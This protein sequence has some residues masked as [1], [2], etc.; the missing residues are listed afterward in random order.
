MSRRI[1]Y[2]PGRM[3]AASMIAA[4]MMAMNS[5]ENGVHLRVSLSLMRARVNVFGTP[6]DSSPEDVSRSSAKC[7]GLQLEVACVG[8]SDGRSSLNRPRPNGSPPGA[9]T[10][11]SRSMPASRSSSAVSNSGRPMTPE[12][13][14]PTRVTK[15]DP[16][17]PGGRR[18]L[19]CRAPLRFRSRGASP[20]R[21]GCES[22][23]R[24]ATPASGPPPGR[25]GPPRSTPGAGARRAWRAFP[26]HEPG[27]SACRGP[28]RR[29][30]PPCPLPAPGPFAGARRPA[31][32]PAPSPARGARRGDRRSPRVMR[33]RPRPRAPPRTR[34]RSV[35]AGPAAGASATRGTRRRR[36][37][38]DLLGAFT[39]VRDV[40]PVRSFALV[41]TA[42]SR[43]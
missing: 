36:R 12:G 4:P 22:P 30:R 42:V 28:R 23:L 20:G 39:S 40:L 34:P 1:A 25:A 38:P 3:A 43:T 15:V 33:F 31:L 13:L 24:C 5:G 27:P 21:R 19:P 41:R 16:H 9:K 11:A 37:R 6:T 17:P 35:A 2:C 7:V 29:S 8:K 26:P 14:P 18:R 32:R 10:G